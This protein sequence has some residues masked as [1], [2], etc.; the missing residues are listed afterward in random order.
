GRHTSSSVA[1]RV[2]ALVTDPVNAVAAT[3]DTFKAAQRRAAGPPGTRW[4]GDNGMVRA[5]PSARMGQAIQQVYQG[6]EIGQTAATLAA[7]HEKNRQEGGKEF[8]GILG[9]MGRAPTPGVVISRD[10][11]RVVIS[12]SADGDVSVEGVAG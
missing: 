4:Q 5:V 8:G 2:D 3:R 11:S 7:P 10:R 1:R 6:Q 9:D 12:K